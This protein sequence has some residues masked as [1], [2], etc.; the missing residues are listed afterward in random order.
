VTSIDVS[1]IRPPEARRVIIE[2][3]PETPTASAST[4]A[5]AAAAAA[6][7]QAKRRHLLHVLRQ[8]V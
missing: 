4:A 7:L 5:A 3:R 6:C 1:A 8:S 2:P